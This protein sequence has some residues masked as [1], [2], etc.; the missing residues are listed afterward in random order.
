[1]KAKG[2]VR[3]PDNWTDPDEGWSA[4]GEA[5]SLTQAAE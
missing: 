1:M 4:V 5:A 3:Y 2:M